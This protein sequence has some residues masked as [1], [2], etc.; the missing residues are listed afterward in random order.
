MELFKI[1]IEIVS[2]LHMKIG[3]YTIFNIS[4]R[5][6]F[7]RTYYIFVLSKCADKILIFEFCRWDVFIRFIDL[8]EF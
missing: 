7:A 4:D 2:N 5:L 8:A 1:L 3:L 6:Q